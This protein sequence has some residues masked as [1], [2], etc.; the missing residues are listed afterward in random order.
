VRELIEVRNADIK[1]RT[2]RGETALR[3]A[4]GSGKS[5]IAA[6][7]VSRGGIA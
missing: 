1:A 6:Y 3:L 7:L 5:D 2:D 4:R